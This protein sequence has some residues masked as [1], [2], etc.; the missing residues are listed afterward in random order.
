MRCF[1]L[2]SHQRF[3]QVSRFFLS[4][5]LSLFL[6]KFLKSSASFLVGLLKILAG[7]KKSLR[8]RAFGAIRGQFLLLV[9][10]GNLRILTVSIAGCLSQLLR[11]RLQ[12][13]WTLLSLGFLR[14]ISCL[15]T[16]TYIEIWTE[17]DLRF[18]ASNKVC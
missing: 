2:R 18:E 16:L 9:L 14:I 5:E 10:C 11:F 4:F 3:F 1:F 7:N 17:G 8:I 6:G 15:W 13:K 12:P